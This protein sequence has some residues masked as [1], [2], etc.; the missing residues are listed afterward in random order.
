MD[1]MVLGTTKFLMMKMK[2]KKCNLANSTQALGSPWPFGA[3]VLI[4]DGKVGWG[5]IK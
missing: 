4:K 5:E 1:K 2:R 3:K